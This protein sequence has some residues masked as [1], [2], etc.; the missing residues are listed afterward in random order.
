MCKPNIIQSYNEKE[1]DNKLLKEYFIKNNINYIFV[2][3][4]PSTHKIV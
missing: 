1:F 2:S 4:K 3:P